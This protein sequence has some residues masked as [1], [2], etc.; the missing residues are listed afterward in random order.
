MTY[1]LMAMKD[2]SLDDNYIIKKDI[3]F[4]LINGS[5]VYIEK[6]ECKKNKS[7]V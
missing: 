2:L 5:S 4:R 3:V 1:L 7:L 6:I